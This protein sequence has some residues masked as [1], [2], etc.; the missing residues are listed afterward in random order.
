MGKQER[1]NRKP[2]CIPGKPELRFHTNPTPWDK[3]RYQ[4][5]SQRKRETATYE[6]CPGPHA[7]GNASASH[8]TW[9]DT[10][11]TAFAALAA[12]SEG[13]RQGIKRRS[14]LLLIR[15][16][17]TVTSSPT[18]GA[19]SSRERFIQ[20]PGAGRHRGCVSHAFSSQSQE[21]GRGLISAEGAVSQSN[22]VMVLKLLLRNHGQISDSHPVCQANLRP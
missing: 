13:H 19:C 2:E 8:T 21:E 20:V 10:F 15:R 14:Q 18:P 5:H 1:G 22:H 12:S 9:L 17:A 11:P 7:A 16:Y 6:G 3:A 4:V